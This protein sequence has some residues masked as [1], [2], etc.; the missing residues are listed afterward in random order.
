MHCVPD[1]IQRNIPFPRSVEIC[2]PQYAKAVR[3]EPL[4]ARCVMSHVAGCGV[5]AAVHFDNQPCGGAI[6]IGDIWTDWLLP[7]KAQTTKAFAA[8]IGP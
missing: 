2:D 4:R 8:Q 7:A 3:L 1:R 5:M 6:K